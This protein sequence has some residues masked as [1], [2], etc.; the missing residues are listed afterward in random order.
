MSAA[1]YGSEQTVISR[2]KQWCNVARD[3]DRQW[4][5]LEYPLDLDMQLA[6]SVLRAN[7]IPFEDRPATLPTPDSEF[8]IVPH[9]RARG[10]VARG[11]RRARGRG[12][13]R[14]SHVS[15][16]SSYEESSSSSSSAQVSDEAQGS[17]FSC[18]SA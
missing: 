14:A 17:G 5:H 4:K 15:E 8:D 6:P 2:L 12:R 18:G 7:M 9:G 13:G 3:F 10:R 11:G 1:V 16:V